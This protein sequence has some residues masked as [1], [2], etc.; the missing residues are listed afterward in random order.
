MVSNCRAWLLAIPSKLTP[1]L[2]GLTD[3]SMIYAA[4]ERE[5]YE[6]LSELSSD[7]NAAS[8]AASLE[9]ELLGSSGERGNGQLAAGLEEHAADE[10]RAHHGDLGRH[11]E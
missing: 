10:R 6:A 1:R 9:E 8:V 5:I 7:E 11:T 3:R 4:L 2:S